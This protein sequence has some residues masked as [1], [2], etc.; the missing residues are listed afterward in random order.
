MGPPNVL[1][2]PCLPWFRA[3]THRPFKDSVAY[4]EDLV[5]WAVFC[6]L[7]SALTVGCY[8]S[9]WNPQSPRMKEGNY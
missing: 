9:L 3:V 1:I 7:A 2:R 4:T 6:R 8:T 5:H